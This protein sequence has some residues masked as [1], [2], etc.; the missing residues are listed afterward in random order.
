MKLL[1]QSIQFPEGQWDSHLLFFAA[2]IRSPVLP[3]THLWGTRGS[4]FSQ[5]RPSSNS[6]GLAD[7]S[8]LPGWPD[9]HYCLRAGLAG[10]VPHHLSFAS[11]LWWRELKIS[12]HSPLLLSLPLCSCLLLVELSVSLK[13]WHILQYAWFLGVE[14]TESIESD[15]IPIFHPSPLRESWSAPF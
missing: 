2:A 5:A 1:K 13:P 8:I 3:P 6:S 11:A 15:N 4:S 7:F 14:Y 9:C 12:V 10:S